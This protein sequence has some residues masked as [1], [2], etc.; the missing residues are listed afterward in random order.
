M[1]LKDILLYIVL[2]TL[3][4]SLVIG[5]SI[6]IYKNYNPINEPGDKDDYE[7]ITAKQL[8]LDYYNL[9]YNTYEYNISHKN[10]TYKIAGIVKDI[11]EIT[12]NM[13]ILL[14]SHND[15]TVKCNFNSDKKDSLKYY[16]QGDE[17]KIVSDIDKLDDENY[18]N[19]KNSK[20]IR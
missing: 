9:K 10:K 12:G 16:N 2:Y 1:D 11:S 4:I 5:L 13:Y 15:I 19:T 17:I 7:L 14:E 20:I 6:S 3:L 8:S 18:L